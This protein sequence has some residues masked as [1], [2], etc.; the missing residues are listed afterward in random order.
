MYERATRQDPS[1]VG[2]YIERTDLVL[3]C[4]RRLVGRG[5]DDAFRSF[6]RSYLQ[7]LRQDPAEAGRTAFKLPRDLGEY[8]SALRQRAQIIGEFLKSL[9]PS[10]TAPSTLNEELVKAAERND[11][12][13]VRA[14]LSQGTDAKARN[15]RAGRAL[16]F[17][18]YNKNAEMVRLLVERG[19][20]VQSL[21]PTQG[22]TPLS[23]AAQLGQSEVVRFLLSKGARVNGTAGAGFTPLMWA[24][25]RPRNTTVVELLLA[26]GADVHLRNRD[27]ETA[28]KRA[29]MSSAADAAHLLL[30]AGSP[31]DTLDVWGWSP[32]T[33]AAYDGDAATAAELLKAGA[34]PDLTGRDATPLML[35]A[36]RDADGV[37]RLLLAHGAKVDLRNS[38]GKTA[39]M[40]ASERGYLAVVRLLLQHGADPRIRTRGGDTA[41]SLARRNG[42]AAVVRALRQQERSLR[43]GKGARLGPLRRPIIGVA[44]PAVLWGR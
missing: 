2:D 13:A 20:D 40:V 37:A 7:E 34:K 8:G 38:R 10:N 5:H 9:G 26:G 22:H 19:A 28:L 1:E 4:A 30:R 36:E 18:L 43:G 31:P 15:E 25:N 14:L 29:A 11:L 16:T 32:L 12:P 17:A 6:F 24:A 44:Q 39:L 42:Q 35:A 23:L 3:A 33:I 41:L 27:G 21:D